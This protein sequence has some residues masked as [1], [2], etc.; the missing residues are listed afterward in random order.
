MNRPVPSREVD[1]LWELAVQA[2][3]PSTRPTK[4]FFE[5]LGQVCGRAPSEAVVV[6][7]GPQ[8]EV[9]AGLI[10]RTWPGRTV[11]T[12][13][14]GDGA[15]EVHARL[16]AARPP[17]AVIATADTSAAEQARLFRNLFMHLPVNGVYLTPKAIP[18]AHAGEAGE[19]APAAA[20]P[21]LVPNEDL[22]E[23]PPPPDDLWEM[24]AAAQAARL[25]DFAPTGDEPAFRDV[26]GLGRHLAEVHVESKMLLITNGFRTQAK[27]TEAETDT[28]L[29]LR[30][31]F[32]VGLTHRPAASVRAPAGFV[33]N[34]GDDPYFRP[35]MH[36]PKISLRR[37]ERPI[38]SRGQL[39]TRSNVIFSDSFRH[40]MSPRLTNIY[41]EESAPRFGYVR[42]DLS[43]P[44]ELPGAWFHL[45]SE[46]P[47]EFGH[48][49]TEVLA[50]LW[51]WDE[52]RRREPQVKVLTT[53]KHDREPKALLPYAQAVFGAFGIGPEQVVAFDRPCR[54]ERL[55][56]A[57]SM[58]ST[59]DYVHPEIVGIW[60]RVAAELASSMPD[61]PDR[62]RRIF[63]SRPV[64]LK[65]S[66]RNTAEVEELFA[67][68]GF[69]VVRPEQLDFAAQIAMFRAADVVAGFAGSA[70]FSLAFCDR[71]KQV[72]LIGPDSYTARNEHMIAT[73][74]GHRIVA[75]WCRA[76]TPHPP[77]SWTKAA[78][79]S[80]YLFDMERDGGFLR[81]RLAEALP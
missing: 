4:A 30:P 11:H 60:D 33:S 8:A 81:D 31:E 58:F 53:F 6:A 76:D 79:G 61:E 41:V 78:F 44:E 29:R 63:C 57:T 73:A 47:D 10:A 77:G 24:V 9:V 17:D 3:W 28:V 43:E 22:P 46:W 20:G 69:A 37:Y 15:S 32:G 52:V 49:T 18:G 13:T 65:R 14:P 50:R 55:Y 48:F 64:E 66:C 7:G 38:C 51:A 62:P 23:G 72:F 39:V 12:V 27:L 80:S 59:Y 21:V 71:P 74:R 1:R 34:L 45:D 75:T 19:Q 70:L 40:H 5:L 36:S 67:G 54:P 42:R 68:Y 56:S 2:H 25:R 26:R 16:S 35:V